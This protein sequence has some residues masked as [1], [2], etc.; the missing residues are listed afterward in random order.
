MIIRNKHDD[1]RFTAD[2]FTISD[3]NAKFL[4]SNGIDKTVKDFKSEVKTSRYAFRTKTGNAEKA[5]MMSVKV[6]DIRKFK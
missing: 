5:P 1:N 2:H 6:Y 3:I 4:K